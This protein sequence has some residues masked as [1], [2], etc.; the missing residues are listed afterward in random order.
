MPIVVFFDVFMYSQTL[1]NVKITSSILAYLFTGQKGLIGELGERGALG[2]DGIQGK[3]GES[4]DSGIAGFAGK[5]RHP[6][7]F[8]GVKAELCLICVE[9]DYV[10][11]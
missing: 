7:M 10:K 1:Q 2:S 9:S 4:G 5:R 8:S 3:K 6:K 11:L